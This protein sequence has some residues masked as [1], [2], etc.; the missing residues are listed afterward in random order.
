MNRERDMDLEIIAEMREHIS[1]HDAMSRDGRR[2]WSLSRYTPPAMFEEFTVAATQEI[3]RLTAERDAARKELAE[4]TDRLTKIADENETICREHTSV[5]NDQDDAW[6]SA[7][8]AAGKE[9]REALNGESKAAERDT[10]RAEMALAWAYLLRYARNTAT[11]DEDVMRAEG[12]LVGMGLPIIELPVPAPNILPTVQEASDA[13]I[14]I[15]G[16]MGYGVESEA[17]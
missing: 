12:I 11:P 4:L 10:A 1:E 16:A 7:W 14:H 17:E 5:G 9:L 3:N 13:L 8:G 6:V 15:V 2:I